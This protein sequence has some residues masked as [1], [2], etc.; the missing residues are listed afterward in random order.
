MGF[1]SRS[2]ECNQLFVYNIFLLLFRST[3]MAYELSGATSPTGL[4]QSLQE[5]REMRSLYII[6]PAESDD[7]QKQHF[8]NMVRQIFQRSHRNLRILQADAASMLEILRM[9]ELPGMRKLRNITV[10]E[11]CNQSQK[12]AISEL[13]NNFEAFQFKRIVTYH[14]L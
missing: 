7:E 12:E 4:A 10:F 1:T 13:I 3:G 9:L 2:G 11:I 5:A 6:Y 14:V 8:W